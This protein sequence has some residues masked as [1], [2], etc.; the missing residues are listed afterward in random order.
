MFWVAFVVQRR[1]KVFLKQSSSSFCRNILKSNVA[2]FYRSWLLASISGVHSVQNLLLKKVVF[3]SG[4]FWWA[5][6]F[7]LTCRAYFFLTWKVTDRLPLNKR[8]SVEFNKVFCASFWL[9]S[10]WDPS[11]RLVNFDVP[12]FGLFL[13]T[14]KC[15]SRLLLVWKSRF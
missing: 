10:F 14:S 15:V 11:F 3:T 5:R 9:I 12:L 7:E 1:L 4:V 13:R 8:L 2:P 6:N